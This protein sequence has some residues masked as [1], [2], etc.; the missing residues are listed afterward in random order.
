MPAI[1]QSSGGNQLGTE[2]VFAK[3]GLGGSGDKKYRS[4]PA[5]YPHQRDAVNHFASPQFKSP[6][7]LLFQMGSGKTLTALLCALELP[8]LGSTSPTVCVVCDKSL[9]G[10]W[11]AAIRR[12]HCPAG[13]TFAVLSANAFEKRMKAGQIPR[14]ARDTDLLIVDEA[15]SFRNLT[16]RQKEMAGAV[17]S[18]RRVLLLSGTPI[19]NSAQDAV[20][21]AF[22]T[23][24]RADAPLRQASA[25]HVLC[26]DPRLCP[27]AAKLYPSV[28][29]E[30]HRVPM[31]WPQALKYAASRNNSTTMVLD[32]ESW[33]VHRPINNRYSQALVSVLN[34]PF[35]DAETSPKMLAL[36]ANVAAGPLPAVVYSCRVE[37]GVAP[38]VELL[39][40]EGLRVGAIDGSVA[41]AKERTAIVRAYNG[42]ALDVLVLS[43]ASARGTDLL[44]TASFHLL[45]PHNNLSE[46]RQ[47]LA[48]AIRLRSHA[49]RVFSVVHVHHYVA[50]A[51]TAACPASDG[52][53]LEAG[54]RE[55]FGEG[56]R[57][58]ARVIAPA[59][60]ALLA[61]QGGRTH[62]EQQVEDNMAKAREVDACMAEIATGAVRMPLTEASL[63]REAAREAKARAK[64]DRKQRLGKQP[65]HGRAK[66]R[67]KSAASRNAGGPY[68]DSAT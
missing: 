51:P 58:P 49:G 11:A 48:R 13:F 31:T 28:E 3:R 68:L 10:Q 20:G 1:A 59:V 15:Q 43:P 62:D 21:F 5:P 6:C 65:A 55:V 40:K 38:L 35:G 27:G 33:S 50:H 60:T 67:A 61:E 24:G 45:E 66:T 7:W 54:L 30:V 34:M 18:F 8:A 63:E 64:A 52:A 57:Y 56:C 2:V 36:V 41:S 47:T 4:N 16:A 32:G 14:L 12:L 19:V 25:G 26:Y 22:L 44:G 29:T 53:A 9:V 42:G 37:R 46:E 23:A 17:R 39:K